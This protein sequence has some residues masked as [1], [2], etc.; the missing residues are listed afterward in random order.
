VNAP[1]F[2]K[3]AQPAAVA[4]KSASASVTLSAQ[5]LQLSQNASPSK[6]AQV[7]LPKAPGTTDIVATKN[8]AVQPAKSAPVPGIQFMQGD[9]KGGRVNTYA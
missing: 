9:S 3:E 8:A 7:T 2:T 5:A 6:Q 1:P 4:N